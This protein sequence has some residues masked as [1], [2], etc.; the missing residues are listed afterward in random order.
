MIESKAPEHD[1][2]AI[3]VL[4]SL[5]HQVPSES[6]TEYQKGLQ[7]GIRYALMA[8]NQCVQGINFGEGKSGEDMLQRNKV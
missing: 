4:V 2:G 3:D 1:P 5:Y 6:F 8:T 7:A